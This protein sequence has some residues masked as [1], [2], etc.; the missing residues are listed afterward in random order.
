MT[1]TE[2]Q[3]KIARGEALDDIERDHALTCSDCGQMVAL[4]ATLDA[5][6]PG[7]PAGFADRVMAR[8]AAESTSNV[9][10]RPRSTPWYEAQWAGVGLAS[11]AAIVALLNAARFVASVLIP[12]GSFGGAP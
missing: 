1:C 4:A 6:D 8:I 2:T 9:P 12:A 7:V 3:E 11:A 10:E 5:L